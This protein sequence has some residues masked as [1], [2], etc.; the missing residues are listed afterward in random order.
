MNVTV[1]GMG[2]IGLPLAV[3]FARNSAR[4][5]G[6]DVQEKV[7]SQINSGIEPFPGEKDLDTYLK[8]CVADGSL[9][10]TLDKKRNTKFTTCHT[11]L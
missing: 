8:E 1:I 2:K 7:V 4:V 6:L 5:T 10:A 11:K 3:N 9:V